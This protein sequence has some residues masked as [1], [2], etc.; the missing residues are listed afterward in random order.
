MLALKGLSGENKQGL[1]IV[2]IDRFFHRDPAADCPFYLYSASIELFTKK[3]VAPYNRDYS[4]LTGQ[5]GLRSTV[6]IFRRFYAI[7][8]IQMRNQW[9]ES[10][11]GS[12]KSGNTSV[13]PSPIVRNIY[14]IPIVSWSE[15]R[16]EDK[17]LST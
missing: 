13:A 17:E 1:K 2:S 4:G 16:L 7:A 11:T 5:Y 14:S 6:S 8:Q 3:V 10:P 9:Q 15:E 12:K